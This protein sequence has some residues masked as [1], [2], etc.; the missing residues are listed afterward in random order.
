MA[1]RADSLKPAN[2]G[3]RAGRGAALIALAFVITAWLAWFLTEPLPNA[4]NVGGSVRRWIFLARALPAVVPGVRWRESYL[5]LACMELSHVEYLP[6]RLPIAAS[7]ALILGAALGLGHLIL[8]GLR[9]APLLRPVERLPLAFGLGTIALSALTLVLGRLGWLAPWPI[10]LGLAGFA[11][12]GAA[13][14]LAAAAR[15]RS[16]RQ[17]VSA[18]PSRTK[19]QG[20]A[21][22]LGFA[23]VAGPFLVLMALGSMLPTIDFDALEYH[24]QAPKEYYQAG[25]IAFLPHNVYT[26]MPSGVEMLHLLGM[27]VLGDWWRG[28][29][30]GQL[31]VML[32]AP[33]AAALIALTARRIGSPRAAWVSAVVYLTTPWIYRLAVIPYVEGPLCYFHSA[34]IWLVVRIWDDDGLIKE[35][36]ALGRPLARL[37]FLVGVL[38]GGAMASKYPALISAVLPF[39][40]AALVSAWRRQFWA[41]LLAYAGGVA[42]VTS[43]WLI[44]NLIDTGNPVYPLAY[45]IFGG[46][47]WDLA[48]D[49]KWSAAHGRRPISLAALV[50]NLLDVA[51]RSDWQS[52]LFTALAP[53]ALLRPGSRRFT[54]ILW[55]YIIYIFATWWLLT[56]RLDRFWLPLLPPLAI[57]TG[58]GADWRRGR[59]WTALLVAVMT[60]SIVTNLTYCTT[61]LVGL[62]EW[63]GDLDALRTQVPETLDPAL[64]RLDAELPSDAKVLLVGQASVFHLRHPIIYNTVFNEEI[65]ETLAKDH[66]AEEV[67]DA[68]TELNVAYVYVDWNAISRYRSPGNYGF[69]DF[70]TPELFQRL[71]K[72]GVLGP[73]TRIGPR[74]DLYEVQPFGKRRR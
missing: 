37:W 10:R 45:P 27:V 46:S 56:H 35:G 17:A 31:L 70:V 48:R 26:S 68:L 69:T 66:S 9:V 4:G 18:D 52:P 38:A 15:G 32:H 57:L 71:V 24:I 22:I 14:E 58:L 63:T 55:I 54:A 2:D 33:M 53:L 5:G 72:E 19:V 8:R 28:A 39:G 23:L 13:W 60:V 25:R 61:A 30:V 40:V 16:T 51:G 64:A 49:L 36:Q 34:L 65:I 6:Q 42:L 1:H 43:P 29:L 47:H 73:S 67:H 41:I 50:D 7:A 62:N 11:V 21:S 44:K 59:A 20:A 12:L 3:R 74:Q